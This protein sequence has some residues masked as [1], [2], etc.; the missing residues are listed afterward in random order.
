M[1]VQLNGYWYTHE[2]IS[3]AL[4]KKGYTIICDKCEDKRGTT[5]VEWHAIKDDEEISV[6][7]TLQSVAIKEFHKKPPLV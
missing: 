2:E 4:T 1:T 7:N 5:I 3:E 6:L